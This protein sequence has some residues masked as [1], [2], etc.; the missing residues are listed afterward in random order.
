M[1]PCWVTLVDD[2]GEM[3]AQVFYTEKNAQEYAVE[4]VLDFI[5]QNPDLDDF[6]D[7]DGTTGSWSL[8]IGDIYERATDYL[9]LNDISD[10]GILVVP[11]H[12]HSRVD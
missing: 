12:I 7:N 5:R 9:N 11:R 6:D 4:V 2:D 10:L 1:T 8:W 3:D